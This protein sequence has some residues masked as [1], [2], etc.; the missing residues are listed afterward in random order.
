[1]LDVKLNSMKK[2]IYIT[3]FTFLSTLAYGQQYPMYT[4]YIFNCFGFNPAIAG[5]ENYWD[6]RLTYRTQ[7][8]GLE[9]APVTQLGTIHGPLDS[10]VENLGMGVMFFNDAAGKLRRTGGTAV[11]SYGIPILDFAELRVGLS[12]GG[13]STR[14]VNNQS[15]ISASEP[16]FVDGMPKSFDPELSAG[17]YLSFR[18]GLYAGFSIPQLNKNEITF[19]DENLPDRDLL[20]H[21]Y[22]MLGYRFNVSEKMALEP[23]VL[24]KYFNNATPVQYDFGMRA[25]LNNKFWIG[26]SYRHSAAATAM[27][28]YEISPS[29]MFAYAFDYTTSDL[30]NAAATSHEISVAFKF[31]RNND[32]DGDGIK[33]KKDECPEV[34]GVEHLNGCPEEAVAEEDN[35]RD[36]DGII[37]AEDNCPDEKGPLSNE[38]CPLDGDR[39]KD[40]LADGIDKC[41]K[42]FGV[43]TNEGCPIDDRDKDGI[44]DAED[45]CP[46]LPGV[47]AQAGCPK[48]DADGDSIVDAMDDCPETP[49]DPDNAGCPIATEAEKMIL[50]LAIRNLYFDTSKDIIKSESYRFLNKL[51]ELMANKPALKVRITGHTDN[52]GTDE[53]NL[54]LSKDR[55]FSVKKHLVSKGV[56]EKQLEI[57]YYGE[58]MPAVQNVG[59]KNLALNRRVEMEF[60]WD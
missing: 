3:I 1:M 15:S 52:R 7:W 2:S 24:I 26:G 41:P 42:V 32:K 19:I 33:D 49:G 28:G 18:N 56:L 51:A 16:L 35:D 46:D 60:I 27:V 48:D 23:S 30:R 43:V 40:G 39:D 29:L 36:E 59:E 50:D 37:D 38:G 54:Q 53:D 9:E 12:A 10:L 4:N 5:T 11:L 31:G 6:A 34:P 22:G 58:S 20:P 44:V 25:L 13:F 21:Y 55:A 45:N 47:V 57:E 8:V 17:A 14:L